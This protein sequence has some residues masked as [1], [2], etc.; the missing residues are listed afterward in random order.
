MVKNR[1]VGDKPGTAFESSGG[2]LYH[3][4]AYVCVCD[5]S[6]IIN[7]CIYRTFPLQMLHVG[8]DT[9]I[10]YTFCKVF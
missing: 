2:I 3:I 1:S 8:N 4:Y 6:F 7:T 5:I 9:A 10:E